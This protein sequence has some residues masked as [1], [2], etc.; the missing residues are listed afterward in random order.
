MYRNY[1]KTM[2]DNV[3]TTKMKVMKQKSRA[4]K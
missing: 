2:N 3:Y 1:V 4:W